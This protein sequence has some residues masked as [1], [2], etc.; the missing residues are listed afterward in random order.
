MDKS[1]S[2][3]RRLNNDLLQG[4]VLSTMLFN[5]YTRDLPLPTTRCKYFLYA[6]DLVTKLKT[7]IEKILEED[8]KVI[9]EYHTGL[10]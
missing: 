9:K 4:S 5:I 8:I 7:L 3:W 1:K 10:K 6:D 2:R